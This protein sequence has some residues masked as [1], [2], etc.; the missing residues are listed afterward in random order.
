M[1]SQKTEERRPRRRRESFV[2]L[3]NAG[4]YI[5]LRAAGRYYGKPGRWVMEHLVNKGRVAAIDIDGTVMI[6]TKSMRR[7]NAASRIR[8]AET[9]NA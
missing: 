4:G 5:S 7:W 8:A 1:N 2:D 3:D 9:A 6:E